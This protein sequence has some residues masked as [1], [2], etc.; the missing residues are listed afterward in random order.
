MRCMKQYV[1]VKGLIALGLCLGLLLLWAQYDSMS[2]LA[3]TLLVLAI[4]VIS[5]WIGD[6]TFQRQFQRMM[7]RVAGDYAYSIVGDSADVMIFPYE[8]DGDKVETEGLTVHYQLVQPKYNWLLSTTADV[9]VSFIRMLPVDAPHNEA[10]DNIVER[11]NAVLKDTD[12]QRFDAFA[13]T[14]AIDNESLRIAILI[15]GQHAT[16][17]RLRSLQNA[18][19][20]A[21][22]EGKI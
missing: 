11:I 17:T 14:R 2:W 16:T 20:A 8:F 9:E 13:V 18:L 19:I 15:P 3:L 12:I 22:A 21:F 7:K 5:W 1:E 6:N 10:I 4:F